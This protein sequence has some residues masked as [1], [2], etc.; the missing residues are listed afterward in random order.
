MT[1]SSTQDV[2][3]GDRRIE[4]TNRPSSTH[5]ETQSNADLYAPPAYTVSTTSGEE[6]LDAE[7]YV[8]EKTPLLDPHRSADRDEQ[9]SP[10]YIPAPSIIQE[11]PIASSSRAVPARKPVDWADISAHTIRCSVLSDRPATWTVK[12][13]KGMALCPL[14]ATILVREGIITAKNLELVP[15]LL[16]TRSDA[17]HDPTDPLSAIALSSYD[18]LG[19]VLLGVAGGPVE[20]ARNVGPLARTDDRRGVPTLRRRNSAGSNESRW[21]LGEQKPKDNALMIAPKA[22]VHFSVGTVKGVRKIVETSFKAPM[23]FSHSLTRGWHNA[24]K[25]YGEQLRE[26]EDVVDLKSGLVVSGK[27]FGFGVFDGLKDFFVMPVEGARKEG[28]VGLGKGV[29]KGI[30]NLVCNMGEAG[31][32][33]IGYSSYGIYKEIQKSASG[34]NVAARNVVITLG[35]VEF[36]QA[37]EE[38]RREV[39]KRWLQVQ[40]RQN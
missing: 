18:V 33:L 34:G 1:A 19:D 15:S 9:P 26:H 10:S 23:T 25:M 27:A 20:V 17:A 30:G 11:E 14:A 21:S 12:K 5:A 22:A 36:E 4:D 29:G 8:P 2:N 28:V 6:S 3:G 7:A 39:I 24:P 31:F 16:D 35:E 40:M 13:K 32:G 38:E 37:S